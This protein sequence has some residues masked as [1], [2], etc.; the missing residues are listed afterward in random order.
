MKNTL[1]QRVAK[2]ET[3]VATVLRALGQMHR[4]QCACF[5]NGGAQAGID[6]LGRFVCARCSMP[7]TLFV[8]RKP[9][10][11]SAVE[12]LASAVR[13]IRDAQAITEQSPRRK[14][15]TGPKTARKKNS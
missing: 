14:R 9:V 2:I 15:T 7:L 8:P 11:A 6:L 5:P 1:T 12:S 4:M 3:D 13:S 10:D